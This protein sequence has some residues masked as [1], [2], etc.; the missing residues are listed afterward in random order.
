MRVGVLGS[1][2]LARMMKLATQHLNVSFAFVAEPGEATEAVHG[3]GDVIVADANTTAEQL[4]D[5]MGQPQVVTVEK[6]HVDVARLEALSAF[7]TV[8]PNPKAVSITQHREREKH[9]LQQLGIPTAEFA[10][11]SHPAQLKQAVEKLGYPVIVKSCE[12]GYDGKNQ[13][14]LRHCADWEQLQQLM[15]N[16]SLDVVIERW[17][18]F[19]AEV[20]LLAVRTVDG[21]LSYYP[22]TQNRH[23]NG[24][25]FTSQAP[26]PIASER[27]QRTAEA[28]LQKIADALDYVGV[29]AME[30]FVVGDQLWVNELAPRVHNSGH[31][32]QQGCE[33]CQF[34]NHIRA[35]SHLP[36]G[37]TTQRCPAGMLNLLGKK[38]AAPERSVPGSV[39]HWYNKTCKPGRKVG[40][41]NVLGLTS[42]DVEN[43]LRQLEATLSTTQ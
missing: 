36:L 20:S 11:A 30:C 43:A 39:L 15:E 34:E 17:V 33:T 13:W 29:L 4:Y 8:S 23:V 38:I 5:A 31:W 18:D 35:I 3:L 42:A 14:R 7:C 37:S 16:E 2:Q 40:H 25:L 1:G 28:Y 27:L 26:A 22:L 6:E 12:S 9:F 41:I 19:S 32:T 24:I 10:S 21:A